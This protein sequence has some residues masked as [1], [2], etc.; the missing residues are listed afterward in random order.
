MGGEGLV[1]VLP[2]DCTE[3]SL[4]PL[5]PD[6]TWACDELCLGKSDLEAKGKHKTSKTLR[7]DQ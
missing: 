4:V 1:T 5:D 6:Q 2:W 3:P 7:S